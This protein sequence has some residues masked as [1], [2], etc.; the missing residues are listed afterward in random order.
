MRLSRLF[1]DFYLHTGSLAMRLGVS[2][3]VGKR[4][5]TLSDRFDRIVRR[6]LYGDLPSKSEVNG[7]TI[8]HP[9]EGYFG[10]ELA[11][12]NYE[13]LSTKVIQRLLQ[14]GMVFVDVGAHVGYYT[15][16]ASRA[17]Y[18]GGH[19]YAFEPDP[20]TWAFLNQNITEN[21]FT[22]KTTLI[23][24]AVSAEI[25]QGQLFA[26]RRDGLTNSILFTP[27]VVERYITCQTTTLDAFFAKQGWPSVDLIKIDVEGA[28]HMI[29]RGMRELSARNPELKLVVEFGPNNLQGDGVSAEQ[30]FATL[31]DLGFLSISMIFEEL[32]LLNIPQDIPVLLRRCGNAFVNLLCEKT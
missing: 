9:S 18:P 8:H 21:N 5:R 26:G 1:Y 14:P 30:F 2:K 16:L 23:N 19:V 32:E 15:L 3:L 6:L 11:T 29:L 10:I 25:G 13:P 7:F 22:E 12:G 20:K 4:G 28:E 24:I 17:V 27:G 31:S